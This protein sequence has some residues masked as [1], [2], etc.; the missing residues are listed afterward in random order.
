MAVCLLIALLPGS[1]QAQN[2]MNQ[3]KIEFCEDVSRESNEAFE[4]LSEATQDL[5]DCAVEFDDCE[6]G[7]FNSNPA[8]CLVEFLQCTSE[9]NQDQ[10]RACEFFG[11]R[12]ANTFEEAL[13][14][15]RQVDPENGEI[16]FLN[17][18][19][20][21]AGQQCLEPAEFSA[22]LCAGLVQ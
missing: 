18:L 12:L 22:L 20:R 9:A 17:F 1:A 7:L 11:N 2:S 13:R 8:S 4:D 3:V 5:A 21:N 19:N 6:T 14:D 10:G 16:R 15:A